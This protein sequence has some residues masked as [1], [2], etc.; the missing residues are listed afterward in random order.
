MSN[1]PGGRRVVA[2]SSP[3]ITEFLPFRKS[4]GTFPFRKSAGTLHA[5]LCRP[6]AAVATTTC[7]ISAAA[8]PTAPSDTRSESAAHQTRSHHQFMQHHR[9]R[10]CESRLHHVT[11]MASDGIKFTLQNIAAS[12]DAD[13][14]LFVQGI[15]A[16]GHVIAERVLFRRQEPPNRLVILT[17]PGRH[18]QTGVHIPRA[19]Q[20]QRGVATHAEVTHLTG[21]WHHANVVDGASRHAFHP[22]VC[23]G[24]IR[25]AAETTAM[26]V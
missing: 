5:T 14:R 4:A 11:G 22:I 2:M 8:S 21:C 3:D 6:I 15:G 10:R 25:T 26:A 9:V 20:R 19:M 16:E 7:C 23:P 13:R 1:S 24:G 12:F 18:Q 17:A